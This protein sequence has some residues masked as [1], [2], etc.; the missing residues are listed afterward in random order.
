MSSKKNIIA[1]LGAG[2]M[3]TAVAQVLAGNGHEVRIWNWEGDDMPLRH[4]EK[5][6]E[7]KKYLP[8]VK[9]SKNIIPKFKIEEALDMADMVFFVVPS[10]AMEYTISFAA[11]SIKNNAILVDISKGIEPQSLRLIPHIITKH[12]RPKLKK[13]VVTVSGPAVAGQMVSGQFTAMNVASKNKKAVKKVID[14]FSNK[15]IRLVPTTD[16]IGVEVGGS[17]KNVYAIAV[18]MCDGMGYGLNTKAAILTKSLEEIADLIGAM[19]GRKHTA[20]ELA[21]LGDLIGTSLCQDS[22][23]RTL[24]EYMGKGLTSKQALK[25][26]KQTTEGVD[27]TR[28][29]LRLAKKHKVAVPFA[30]M[31]GRCIETSGNPKNI[32]HNYLLK[33]F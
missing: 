9:L 24:G 19:G 6:C 29:L 20:Y 28:C 33:G 11:R 23:N 26:I 31:I 21:G 2:N 17:F 15:Y 27:A 14:V 8:G 30:K 16:V 22:R 7:N 1:V 25:K 18:G 12:V 32:F 3:G 4:I 5:Y 10:G 13:N